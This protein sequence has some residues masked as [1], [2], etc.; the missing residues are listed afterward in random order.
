MTRI[1]LLASTTL[2]PVAAWAQTATPASNAI[3][4]TTL[5]VAIVGGAFSVI[6]IV[7]TALINSKMRNANDAATL[8]KAVQNSVGAIQQ[9]ADGIISTY[10]PT[11]TVPGVSPALAAGVQYV[12]DHAG[13]EA[14]RLGVTPESVADKVNAQLGLVKLGASPVVT[15]AAP[16]S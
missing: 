16:A 9:A 8:T 2:A 14:A 11:V 7:A 3:D 6:G 10:K 4:L 1:L 5:M 12:L 13:E 15:P